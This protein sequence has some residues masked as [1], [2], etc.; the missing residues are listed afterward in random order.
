MHEDNPALS[1][2]CRELVAPAPTEFIGVTRASERQ[3]ILRQRSKLSWPTVLLMEMVAAVDG[4]RESIGRM[5]PLALDVR[6]LHSQQ[7]GAAVSVGRERVK[8]WL[9]SDAGKCWSQDRAKLLQA[10]DGDVGA[11][12]AN[13]T[14]LAPVSSSLRRCGLARPPLLVRCLLLLAPLHRRR[15]RRNEQCWLVSPPLLVSWLIR[16]QGH[17]AAAKQRQKM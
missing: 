12:E 3:A 10:D 2:M 4:C 8:G 13:E 11:D 5:V 14:V 7:R 17:R 9:S 16:H 6:H 1:R 15:D